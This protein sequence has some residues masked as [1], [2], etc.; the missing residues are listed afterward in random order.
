MSH[1]P[2]FRSGGGL[3]ARTRRY[4]VAAPL[5]NGEVLIAGGLDDEG[6]DSVTE[7]FHPATD[8]FTLLGEGGSDSA[9]V[10]RRVAAIAAPLTNGDVVISGRYTPGIRP[11][12]S[13]ELFDPATDTFATTLTLG[14]KEAPLPVR[15]GSARGRWHPPDP[16]SAGSQPSR[17]RTRSRGHRE[18]SRCPLGG[19]RRAE[20]P[21]RVR[22]GAWLLGRR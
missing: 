17:C 2:L 12:G 9:L 5:A 16:T 21:T 13:A 11:V 3:E 15:S 19:V 10:E 20:P 6:T 18:R 7:L 1:L 22:S 4:A 14:G 8:T